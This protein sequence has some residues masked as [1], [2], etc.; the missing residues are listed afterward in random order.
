MHFS[1]YL[2]IE[3]GRRFMWYCSL[4]K[5]KMMEEMCYCLFIAQCKLFGLGHKNNL[6]FIQHKS[7]GRATLVV[8][9]NMDMNLI[10]CSIV[11]VS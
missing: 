10:D 1:V 6:I 4:N 9:V 7:F 5:L 8:S 3:N 2:L 11:I